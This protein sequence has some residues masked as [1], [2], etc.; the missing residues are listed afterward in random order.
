MASLSGIMQIF[1]IFSVNDLKF[2]GSI[3]ITNK[4]VL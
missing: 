1:E 4:Q 2:C 3:L